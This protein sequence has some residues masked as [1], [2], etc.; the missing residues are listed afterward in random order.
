M[1]HAIMR[2]VWLSVKR[3]DRLSLSPAAIK[4]GR[5]ISLI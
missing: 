1:Y 5:I 4:A 2:S 3:P